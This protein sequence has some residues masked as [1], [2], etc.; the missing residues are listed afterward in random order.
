MSE[1]MFGNYMRDETDLASLGAGQ[2]RE[3]WLKEPFE[4]KDNV[5]I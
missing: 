1:M 4:T 5:P 3:P 2:H